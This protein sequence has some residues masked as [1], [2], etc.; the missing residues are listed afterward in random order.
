[1]SSTVSHTT[2]LTSP[3]RG[4]MPHIGRAAVAA[5]VIAAC[6]TTATAGLARA[7][8][9]GVAVGG[10]PIPLY[11]FAQLTLI[12]AV[13]GAALAAVLARRTRSPQQ[14]FVRVAA[15]LTA[16]SLVPDVV[17]DA[18]VGTKVT[19]AATHLIAAAIIVPVVARRP[20]R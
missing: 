17:V 6:A 1:M 8:G 3:H 18:T 2:A 14:T 7:A 20:A 13:I 11:A 4:A 19:L 9:L 12:D 15:A 5:G 10:E 16:L